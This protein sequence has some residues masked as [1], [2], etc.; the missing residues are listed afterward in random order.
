M[1]KSPEGFN[2]QGKVLM[3]SESNQQDAYLQAAHSKLYD[4][5]ISCL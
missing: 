3:Q 1:E 2:F 4:L 5:A